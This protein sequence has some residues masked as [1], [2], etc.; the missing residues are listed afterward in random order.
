MTD[1]LALERYSELLLRV[2]VLEESHNTNQPQY[3]HS[4]DQSSQSVL[5]IES[6]GESKRA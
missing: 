2:V 3:G 6:S 1:K 4:W 5:T